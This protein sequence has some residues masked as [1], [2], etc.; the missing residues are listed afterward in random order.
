MLRQPLL[1]IFIS[2]FIIFISILFIQGGPV[3]ANPDSSLNKSAVSALEKASLSMEKAAVSLEKIGKNLENNIFQSGYKAG[4]ADGYKAGSNG[5]GV[6]ENLISR[7]NIPESD[8]APA[9]DLSAIKSNLDA[10]IAKQIAD[11]KW[12]SNSNYRGF[13]SKD[14]KKGGTLTYAS[15]NYPPTLRTIGKNANTAFLFMIKELCYESLLKM[16]YSDYSYAPNLA[17]RWAVS[18][19]KQ[20]FFFHIDPKAK[21]MDGKPVIARDIVSTWV[22]MTDPGIDDPFTNDYW[23]KYDKPVAISDNIVMV[24]SKEADWRAFMSIA[25]TFFVLPDHVIGNLSGKDFLNQYQFKMLPGSG[26][27]TYESHRVNEDICLKKRDNWW[28][29]DYPRKIGLYNFGRL[30]FIFIEDENL[31]KEKFKKGDLDWFH[32]N[33]AREWH[34]EFI[35]GR[36]EQLAKGWIQK[37]K[38]YTHRPI[39]VSG[40]AFNMRNAPFDDWR[41]RLAIAHLYNREKMMDKLFFNEYEYIDSAYPNSPYANPDNP[42]IRFNPDK[43]VE[44][45]EEAGWKQSS[46]NSNG[47]LMKEGQPFVITMNYLAKSSER[48]L[49]IFQED[50]KDVGIELNLKMVTWATDL[51]EVGERNFT[52]SSRA[53]TGLLF[54]NPEGQLHSK[55]ADQKHNNNIFG[56][57]NSRVDELCEAYNM[58][59]DQSKRIKM[60]REIDSILMNEH[61]WVYGWYA[62]HTRLLFW[63]K[64]G[65]PPFVLGKVEDQRSIVEYWWFDDKKATQLEKAIETNSNLPVGEEI[66]RWWDENY[67][68]Q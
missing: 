15:T 41:V 3:L 1:F 55:F 53:Y 62:A 52:L 23:S 13:G 19:D 67:K 24:R 33:V 66:V 5:T 48:I 63:N 36:L 42:K 68:K 14:A 11:L 45:L 39:G 21:W 12:E 43:A 65:M 44:L 26:P 6:N 58:E 34:Q 8:S 59:Y 61:A 57:K 60:L 17:D 4:Y 31:L 2:A 16:D 20:S 47:I 56:F 30:K 25:V 27:Y 38:I 32:V 46:R 28:Q 54:P 40:I 35:P 7:S 49:T 64:F 37:R 9:I 18:K 22:L 50:L 51:K 10:S 29:S